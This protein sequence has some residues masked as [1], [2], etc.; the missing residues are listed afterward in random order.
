MIGKL[1]ERIFEFAMTVL[2]MLPEV[3]TEIPENVFE[4]LKGI[5]NGIGFFLP[6]SSLTPIVYIIIGLTGFRII[7][8]IVLKIRLFVP[9]TGD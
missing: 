9:R 5:I 1:I 7:W 6:L 3:Q 2:E 4:S 8:A